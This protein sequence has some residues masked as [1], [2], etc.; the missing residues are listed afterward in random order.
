MKKKAP[1]P[2]KKGLD[3]LISPH[4]LFYILPYMM[5]LLI[6]GTIAQKYVGLFTATKTFFSSFIL[7]VGPL[8]LPGG[9]LALSL[10]FI[11]LT[12][13]F[14]LKSQWTRAGIGSTLTHLGVI[15]LLSGG[16]VTL[17][18]KQEG[19]IILRHGQQAEAFYDYHTRYFTVQKDGKT[20]WQTTTDHLKPGQLLTLPNMPFKIHI[21][22]VYQNSFL[23]KD[24]VLQ[25]MMAKK[26]EETNQV[27][28]RFTLGGAKP[29][30]MTTTEFLQQQ[31][32]LKT[33]QGTYRFILKRASH[34]LP[35]ALQLKELNQDLYPGTDTAKSYA[36]H[37]TVVEKDHTWPA[38]VSMND[39]LRYK[40]YTFYQASVLTLPNGEQAS[41][42]NTVKDIGWLFPY[43]A[44]TLVCIGLFVNA[45]VRRHAKK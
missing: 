12:A 34:N 3:L 26:E 36:S 8:P 27:G 20:I 17:I 28:L 41:V 5:A 43:L 19:F 44:T 13:Y 32:H 25:E 42:L 39:P 15:V 7:W 40:G 6:A 22:A 29:V 11:N 23:D 30:K 18:N 24:G 4:L 1:S 37:F 14:I 45:W 35:F 9:A 16:M 21:D 31:P 2:F 10:L 33:S 38:H